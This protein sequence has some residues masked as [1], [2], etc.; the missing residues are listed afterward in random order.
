MFLAKAV[1]GKAADADREQVTDQV[2][3]YLASIQQ[4]F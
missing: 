2:Q 4:C 3:S 1:F